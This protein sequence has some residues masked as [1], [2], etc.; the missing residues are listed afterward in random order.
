[1]IS[2]KKLEKV[3]D[4]LGTVMPLGLTKYQVQYNMD[5]LRLSRDTLN[6]LLATAVKDFE[7][8]AEEIFIAKGSN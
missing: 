2:I 8:V 7:A 1:M 4:D 3:M 5:V 6:E